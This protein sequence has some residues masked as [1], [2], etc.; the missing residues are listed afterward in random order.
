M[1]TAPKESL[2]AL[3]DD[4]EQRVGGLER[5]LQ[6]I[7]SELSAVRTAIDLRNSVSSRIAIA[8][9]KEFSATSGSAARNEM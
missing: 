6:A 8:P 4:A 3:I 2:I 9:L 1:T 5:E 7:D